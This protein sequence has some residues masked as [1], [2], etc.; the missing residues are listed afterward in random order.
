MCLAPQLCYSTPALRA[1]HS[2]SF[3]AFRDPGYYVK[4]NPFRKEPKPST[5]LK[6]TV[7]LLLLLGIFAF[8]IMGRGT[9]HAVKQRS[10]VSEVQPA[11]ATAD[12]TSPL[13][14]SFA[15]SAG[16]LVA[17]AAPLGT[18]YTTW[19]WLYATQPLGAAQATEPLACLSASYRGGRRCRSAGG[20]RHTRA[21]RCIAVLF[22]CSSTS[23]SRVGARTDPLN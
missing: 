3:V 7:C 8:W 22:S 11:L 23:V 10:T 4:N 14:T 16:P 6:V 15:L 17:D 13:V 2:A 5:Q 1:G 18:D 9:S 20:Q 19:R 12:K 21:S